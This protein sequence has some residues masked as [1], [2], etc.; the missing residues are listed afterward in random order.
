MN[1]L[2]KGNVESPVIP[3]SCGENAYRSKYW[4][5]LN[6]VMEES[7]VLSAPWG[8]HAQPQSERENALLDVI[9]A[10]DLLLLQG[11]TDMGALK[12]LGLSKSRDEL[13]QELDVETARRLSI[14]LPAQEQ[15]RT[16]AG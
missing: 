3:R 16:T 9:G 4:P 15:A 14:Q 8:T 1:S 2:E 10:Y 7:A 5:N 13:V 12:R 11:L 6:G